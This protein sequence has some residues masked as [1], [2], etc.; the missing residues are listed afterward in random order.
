MMDSGHILLTLLGAGSSF[1]TFCLM[2]FPH[3]RRPP[4]QSYGA[5]SLTAS[6]LGALLILVASVFMACA[7]AMWH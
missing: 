3:M 1:V 2:R 6:F 4:F 5:F 7:P